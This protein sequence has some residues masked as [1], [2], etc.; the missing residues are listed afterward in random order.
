M[1]WELLRNRNFGLLWTAQILSTLGNEL[2]NI[3]VMVTIFEQTG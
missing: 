3:G 2:Y 1:Q